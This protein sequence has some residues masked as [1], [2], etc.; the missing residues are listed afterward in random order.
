MFL[1]RAVVKLISG[2]ERES[3]GQ[4]LA[5]PTGTQ[6]TTGGAGGE[7]LSGFIKVQD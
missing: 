4:V 3:V 5:G 2:E 1:V 7:S 6:Y